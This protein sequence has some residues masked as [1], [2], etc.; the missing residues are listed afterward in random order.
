MELMESKRVESIKP[1][2]LTDS[3]R[4]D[5]TEFERKGS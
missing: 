2:E 4:L 5:L 3:V 1:A